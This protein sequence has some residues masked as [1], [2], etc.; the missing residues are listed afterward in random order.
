MTNHELIAS[1]GIWYIDGLISSP[2]HNRFLYINPETRQAYFSN[3]YKDNTYSVYELAIVIRHIIL[4][5]NSIDTNSD[6]TNEE[7]FYDFC[8]YNKYKSRYVK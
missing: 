7:A 2:G 3:T 1:Y 4:I 8:T 6:I 5:N